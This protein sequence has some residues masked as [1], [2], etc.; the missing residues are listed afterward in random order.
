MHRPQLT[1]AEGAAPH[2][3]AT[4]TPSPSSSSWWPRTAAMVDQQVE[5]LFR[6]LRSPFR[7]VSRSRHHACWKSAWR[8]AARWRSGARYFGPQGADR[9]PRH[10]SG[11]QAL[12]DRPAR[13]SCIGSQGDAAF[14]EKLGRRDRPDRHPDRRRQ[15]SLRA[16]ARD[17]PRAVQARPRRR[18]L[19]LRGPVHVVLVRGIRR[20]RAQARNL[21]SS[22]CKELI[23]ELNAWF[24]REGVDAEPGAFAD[25]RARHALLSDAG[26]DRETRDGKAAR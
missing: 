12:R 8:A 21:S 14:L 16:S 2:F 7:A 22:F 20:R 19:R 5:A 26:G 18:P 10:Q 17:V 1:N 6:D 23:D 25:R 9:R 4:G 3:G 11:L 15:P 13:A 24:W